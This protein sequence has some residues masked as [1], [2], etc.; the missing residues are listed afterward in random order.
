MIRGTIEQATG[1]AVSGWLYADMASVR[2]RLVLAFVGDRCV[3]AGR[4]EHFRQDLA[5]AGLA[6]GVLGF[7]F[8][9]ELPEGADTAQVVVRLEDSDAV[10]LQGRSRVAAADAAVAGRGAQPSLSALQWMRAQGWLEQSQYDF[11]RALDQLGVYER[12][13]VLPRRGGKPAERVVLDPAA[14]ALDLFRLYHFDEVTPRQHTLRSL[15]EL[16]D[17]AREGARQDGFEPVLALWSGKP[18]RLIVVEGSHRQ[19]AAGAAA[20]GTEYG[21]G[22]DGL[23]FLNPR[24]ACTPRG[25]PPAEGFTVFSVP[26]DR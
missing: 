25:A 2:D 12:S 4:V 14:A 17:L 23:L 3:G 6:D 21:I 16:P 15:E 19:P 5:D 26:G 1:Q 9:V 22:P 13:L 20:A 11:L 18:A 8:P 10:L 24:C 7:H